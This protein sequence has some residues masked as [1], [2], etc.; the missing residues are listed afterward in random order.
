ML[1]R[2]LVFLYP[3]IRTLGPPLAGLL[4][5][6]GISLIG[7]TM[8]YGDELWSWLGATACLFLSAALALLCHSYTWWLFKLRP[9]GC[10]FIPIK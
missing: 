7:Y 10:L 4:L 5:V 2:F 6:A 8:L 1:F 3:V 9:Q